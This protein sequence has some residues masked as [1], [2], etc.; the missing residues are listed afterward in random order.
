MPEMKT[1]FKQ[2]LRRGS[3]VVAGED[4]DIFWVVLK[5][6]GVGTVGRRKAYLQLTRYFLGS[7][8]IVW[9]G[10]EKSLSPTLTRTPAFGNSI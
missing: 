9:C 10:L 1:K 2:V 8:E 5:S 3:W 7:A 4:K 6:C